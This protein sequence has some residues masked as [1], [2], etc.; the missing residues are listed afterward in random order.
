MQKAARCHALLIL[1]FVLAVRLAAWQV[2]DCEIQPSPTLIAW[3]VTL[4][5]GD[6]AQVVSRNGDVS[7]LHLEKGTRVLA[8]ATSVQEQGENQSVSFKVLESTTV[9]GRELLRQVEEVDLRPGGSYSTLCKPSL[10]LRLK[11]IAHAPAAM[12]PSP[13]DGRAVSGPVTDSLIFWEMTTPLRNKAQLVGR[14]GELVRVR[15]LGY[16]LGILPSIRTGGSVRFRVFRITEVAG[17]GEV[18]EEI[19][20]FN[21]HPG[22][23]HRIPR[24]NLLVRLTGI[25]L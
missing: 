19:E 13:A 6:T 23:E 20:Y 11:E 2:Q 14:A 3:E 15:S 4:N 10:T 21:L 24:P 25:K 17:A 12:V 5:S 1:G 9:E 16:N 22:S 8:V 7:R 18:I